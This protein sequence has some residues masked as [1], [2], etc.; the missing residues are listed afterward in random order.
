MKAISPHII[1]L[2]CP[3]AVGENLQISFEKILCIAVKSLIIETIGIFIIKIFKLLGSLINWKQL[4]IQLLSVTVFLL[5]IILLSFCQL[6]III[7]TLLNLTK[8]TAGRK[9]K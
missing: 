9:G 6:V 5:D 1:Y 4:F 7:L 2:L 3:T 8:F